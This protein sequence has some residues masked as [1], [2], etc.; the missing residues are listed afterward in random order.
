MQVMLVP[1]RQLNC[2]RYI[3]CLTRAA[4]ANAEEFSCPESCSKYKRKLR[5]NKGSSPAYY[6]DNGVVSGRAFC[7]GGMLHANQ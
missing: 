7:E 6:A 1:I 2:A 4:V 3:E 5:Q